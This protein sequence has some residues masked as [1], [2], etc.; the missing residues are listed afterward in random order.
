M[1][2]SIRDGTL[3]LAVAK[4]IQS[5]SPAHAVMASCD[6]HS[7]FPHHWSSAEYLPCQELRSMEQT[8]L[9]QKHFDDM[10]RGVAAIHHQSSEHEAERLLPKLAMAPID[11]KLA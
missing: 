9:F 6:E 2:S 7:N 11:A 1:L 5:P 4:Q 3:I 8:A 10:N